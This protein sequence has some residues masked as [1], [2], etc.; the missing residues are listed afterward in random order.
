MAIPVETKAWTV[1]QVQQLFPE[2][3]DDTRHEL[4]DGEL[5]VSTQPSW[6]HQRTGY[7][8][9]RALDSWGMAAEA[10]MT[11]VAPGVVFSEH[12]AVAP[13][14]VWISR[15]R[16]D[17]VL[18]PNGRLRAAPDL[19]VEVLSPGIRNIQRDREAKLEVYSRRGVREYWI[20]D[21][22][23]RTADVFRPAGNRLHLA[24][25]LTADDTLES[26]LLPGFSCHISEFFASVR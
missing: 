13:D 4:I 11:V 15:Q 14:V 1:T 7:N 3:L 19:V 18:D 23:A 2:S 10:G 16:L 26:S 17:Q 21:W 9:A 8:I 6:Q 25:T 20:V 22:Q 12:E 24:A 5:F